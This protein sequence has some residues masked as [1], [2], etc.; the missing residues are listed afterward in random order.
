MLIA[1]VV[2]DLCLESC[3]GVGLFSTETL[4]D[5]QILTLVV[6]RM[7]R[8]RAG[9]TVSLVVG[10][11]LWQGSGVF[12]LDVCEIRPPLFPVRFHYPNVKDSRMMFFLNMIDGSI[13]PLF[14]TSTSYLKNR[15]FSAVKNTIFDDPERSFL[16]R[17]LG[18][19]LSMSK[20]VKA[21]WWHNN[22]REIL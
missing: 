13:H 3:P 20:I 19:V 21:L 8:V 1:L 16:I 2:V 6:K 18:R 5:G 17:H 14:H 12:F 11:W 10:L 9:S 15:L 22:A 4:K 7:G